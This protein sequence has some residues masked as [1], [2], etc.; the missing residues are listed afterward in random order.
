MKS[1]P[2]KRTRKRS[3]NFKNIWRLPWETTSCAPR[4]S[5]ISSRSAA[6]HGLTEEEMVALIETELRDSGAKRIDPDEI[7][8]TQESNGAAKPSLNK[9]DDFMR[10]LRLSG[11]D[12]DAMTDDQRDAFINMA[13]NLG[14]EPG[15][16]EDMVD[17]YLEEVEEKALATPVP[18]PVVRKVTPVA[19]GAAQTAERSDATPRLVIDVRAERARFSN[20]DN[21]IGDQMVFIPSTEFTMGSEAVDAAP[22]ERPL[23]QVMVSR[24]Y[25][26]RHLITNAQYEQFDPGHVRKRAAGR[27]GS[28]SGHSCKQPGCDQVLPMAKHARAA[29][30]SFADG[31]RMGICRPRD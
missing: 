8:K 30:I 19:A 11:L 7:G 25:I 2:R 12:S 6:E 4:K 17:V 29:E 3:L 27:G 23:T 26:S 5:A 28:A 16:A 9:N 13:E 21:S 24:F 20:F 14:I 18:P 1:W 15:D 10:M 22:N 31:S